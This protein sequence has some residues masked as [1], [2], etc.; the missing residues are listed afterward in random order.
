[1]YF[2]GI[3]GDTTVT[4]NGKTVYSS[5]R[6]HCCRNMYGMNSCFGL[7]FGGF[8]CGGFGFGCMPFSPEAVIGFGIGTAVAPLLPTIFKG[9]GK[10]IVAIGKGIGKLWNKIFHK[11][12]KSTEAAS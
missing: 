3:P 5:R 1:M 11:K 8:G 12:S 9:I 7:G 10:G 6:H 2:G 4:V